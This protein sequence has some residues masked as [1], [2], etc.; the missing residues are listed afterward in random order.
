MTEIEREG[1]L[2]DR[3]EKISQ[4]QQREEVAKMARAKDKQEGKEAAAES[5]A[6]ESDDEYGADRSRAGRDRKTTGTSKE[7]MRGIEKLKQ[8]RAQKGNKEKK[9]SIIGMGGTRCSG[10]VA[11]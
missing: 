6:G 5:S 2:G 7:K 9:V 3:L 8:S 11:R 4:A 10:W 1:I